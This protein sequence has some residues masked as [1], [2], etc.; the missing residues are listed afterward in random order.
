MFITKYFEP[1]KI[2]QLRTNITYFMQEDRDQLALAWEWMKKQLWII[3][4]M[5]WN[6]DKLFVLLYCP[7]SKNMLDTNA[8]GT[9]MGKQVVEAKKLL[10]ECNKTMP[11]GM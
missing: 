7:L 1:I 8:G 9:I 5:V 6:N 3:L 10:E 2:M 4:T 11:N